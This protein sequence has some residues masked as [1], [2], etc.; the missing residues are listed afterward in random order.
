MRAPI[1]FIKIIPYIHFSALSFSYF[2]ALVSALE[3]TPLFCR[4]CFKTEIVAANNTQYL[5]ERRSSDRLFCI[6]VD[7][8]RD[9]F[10]YRDRDRVE[11]VTDFIELTSRHKHY[12]RPDD[13]TFEIR[14]KSGNKTEPELEDEIE[15][16]EP[17]ELS[18]YAFDDKWYLIGRPIWTY[19]RDLKAPGILSMPA[20]RDCGYLLTTIFVL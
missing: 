11:N 1:V 17:D 18:N 8:L 10:R 16:V 4:Y 15:T 5:I 7:N 13:R 6:A 20:G 12:V 9:G 19:R 3:P 14:L 2:G